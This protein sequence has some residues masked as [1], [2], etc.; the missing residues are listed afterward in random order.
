MMNFEE[1]CLA[2]TKSVTNIEASFSHGTLFLNTQDSEV[3]T[4]VFELL[5]AN[6]QSVGI[7]YGKCGQSETYYDFV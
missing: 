5:S 7:Q 3:A 4:K 6:N 2:I 1:R